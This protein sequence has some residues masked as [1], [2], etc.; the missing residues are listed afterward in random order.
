MS[1]YFP[2]EEPEE[3]RLQLD[4]FLLEI[5]HAY[6]EGTIRWE[7]WNHAR[8]D[9]AG[10]Y[11]QQYLGYESASAFLEAYGYTIETPQK[12]RA[13]PKLHP[14]IC[15]C[16]GA[17]VIVSAEAETNECESCG[18]EFSTAEAIAQYNI[19]YGAYHAVGN[20]K[21][22][23]KKAVKGTY[24][25]ADRGLEQMQETLEEQRYAREEAER[26]RRKKARRSLVV[27]LVTLAVP[28]LLYL[29]VRGFLQS[30]FMTS[31]LGVKDNIT[32][33]TEEFMANANE[34]ID[35]WSGKTDAAPPVAETAPPTPTPAPTMDL[36]A[37]TITVA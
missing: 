19:R 1:K 8:W 5:Y 33:A 29:G 37:I 3:I 30:E 32:S 14:G 12:K 23:R 27:V 7:T 31:L 22:L 4:A 18:R 35:R 9:S 26:E 36:G 28:F 25:L 20:L 11:L 24:D 17:K 6:P 15:T 21:E 2:G 13:A 10:L 16:C 34:Q